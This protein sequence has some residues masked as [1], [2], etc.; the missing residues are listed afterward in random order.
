MINMEVQLNNLKLVKNKNARH[1]SSFFAKH[2]YLKS[3]AR[4]CPDVFELVDMT[5]GEIVGAAQVGIPATRHISKDTHKEI[6]RFVLIP[7][8]AKNTASYFISRIVKS[9]KQDY[10]NITSILTYAD[11]DAG[12]QGTIY[13]ASNFKFMGQGKPGQKVVTLDGKT[14]LHLRTAYNKNVGVSF[15]RRKLND[16]LEKVGYKCM[17][18]AGKLK[19]EME[20]RK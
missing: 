13:L 9:I 20:I 11:P 10:P 4:G 19:F 18:T 2:H 3:L 17:K 12:H 7:G 6:R 15:N 14:K 8:V 1:L 16:T 5:T